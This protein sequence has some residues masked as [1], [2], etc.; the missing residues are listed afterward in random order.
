V[1][2]IDQIYKLVQRDSYSRQ[3][4]FGERSTFSFA[5]SDRATFEALKAARLLDRLDQAVLERAFR[6]DLIP[7]E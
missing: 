7:A 5:R 2:Q 4:A 1:Q 6:G 3:I